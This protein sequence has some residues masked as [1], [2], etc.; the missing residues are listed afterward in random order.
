MP[1]I[2]G[3]QLLRKIRTEQLSDAY[4]IILSGFA[5]FSYAQEAIRYKCTDYLL[6]P[7]NKG[8]LLDVLHKVSEMTAD[9]EAE[10][11]TSRKM[12]RE[13]LARN[14]I[15]VINGKYDEVNLEIIREQMCFEGSI[16]YIEIQ[17]N[18]ELLD[19]ETADEEKRKYQRR[20]SEICADYL[21]DYADHCVFDVSGKENIYDIGFVYCGYMA[22]NDFRTEKNYLENFLSYLREE[23]KLPVIMLVGK[24]VDDI[25]NIAKSYSTACI[26]R[27]CQSFKNLKDI[28]YYDE[29][30][31]V[32]GSGAVLCKKEI[33]A[34][35]QV[36]EQNQETEIAK[37]V[38]DFFEEIQRIGGDGRSLN[39]DY[40][41][42]QL[43]HLATQQDDNVNQEEILRLIS[44]RSF[45]EGLTRGSKDHVLSFSCEYA[46]YLAQLRQNVSGGIL[47]KIEKEIREHFPE[48]LTLKGLSVKARKRIAKTM[49]I[50][51]DEWNVW[52]HS[53]EAEND[54]K[55]NHPW[56][57]AP[58]M[59]E[60]IYNF[61][62]ALLVGLM[63]ITLISHADRVKIACLAQLVNVIAPIMTDEKGGAWRQT[64]FY[65]FLHASKYGRGT[66]LLPVI[67]GTKH[68]T[69]KHGEITDVK[70]SAVYN[71]EKEEVTVFAVNRNLEED[72]EL[73]TDVRCFEG[74][75]VLEYIV[76]ENDD[77]K[78]VNTLQKENVYPVNA[79]DRS[80]LND[81][82]M[83]SVLKKASWNVIRLGK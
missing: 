74:Y 21:G 11:R 17:L 9:K 61:E 52:F 30:V 65:P 82:Y 39:I 43:I 12:E 31:Q 35:L 83:T 67:S 70:A 80:C 79:N 78:A 5:E 50:S 76:M 2:S 27:S 66:A 3:L 77:L 24:K 71:E 49:N 64:I 34:L 73:T 75:R 33:D 1:E 15:A 51:F 28:Y 32:S 40:L 14:L 20:L 4:F 13:Y 45:K 68:G 48:N 54:I 16:R 72:V 42:F 26:L 56:Q 37:A 44:E 53:N 23:A 63:L 36:I 10:N 69:S 41:L 29:E 6:K 8:Q 60:D 58:P 19:E 47:Q 57:S 18:E 62:D 25:R 22:E 59:L 81:G 46:R 38:D 55:E 7:I